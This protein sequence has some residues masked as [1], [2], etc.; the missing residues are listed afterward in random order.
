MKKYKYLFIDLDDT[1]WDFHGNAKK[2]LNDVFYKVKLNER[3][4]DFEEFYRIY[5]KKNMELWSHYGQGLITK[6]YLA[7]ER[8]LHPLKKVGIEDDELAKKMNTYFLNVL[9]TKTDLMP[10]A[11]Q[12]LEVIESRNIPVTL[13]SNGFTEVQYKKIRNAGI[14]RYFSHIVLSEEAGALKPSP[15]IFEYALG[16]NNAN[17]KDVLM[18][19]D[20][21]EADIAGALNAGI[22]AVYYN[23]QR[24]KIPDIQT[25]SN[26]YN[27]ERLEEVIPFF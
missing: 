26:L 19:G 25:E 10:Y 12:L 8:F 1:V 20:N 5:S 17:K 21:F 3:Y 6:E 2:A 23:F 7:K 24:Q 18:V 9:A 22:D 14:E 16:K 15:Q 11:L 4:N 27:I 13:L